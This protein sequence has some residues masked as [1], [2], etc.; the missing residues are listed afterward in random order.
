MS[1]LAASARFCRATAPHGEKR[2]R[3]IALAT[4]A[5]DKFGGANY[6][7]LIR[8]SQYRWPDWI[9]RCLTQG[10]GALAALESLPWPDRCT[11]RSGANHH[12]LHDQLSEGDST[13][14]LFGATFPDARR[15]LA[16]AG[17][18][19]AFPRHQLRGLRRSPRFLNSRT[20]EKPEVRGLTIAHDAVGVRCGGETIGG[21][22]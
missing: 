8:P 11:D 4:G 9:A 12:R 5:I 1:R 2:L 10:N 20:A 18:T 15:V 16:P 21:Q 17:T 6:E 3:R 13:G 19:S 14:I 22:P 7:R